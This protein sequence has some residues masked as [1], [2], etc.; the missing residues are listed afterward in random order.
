MKTIASSNPI[1][2]RYIDVHGRR[3]HFLEHGDEAAPS[4][5]LLHGCGSLAQE[6]LAP[7]RETDL[8]IVAPDRPGYGFSE[9][10]AGGRGPL[11]QSYWLEEL[12]EALQ[13]HDVVLAGHSI[14]CAPLLILAERR[15]DLVS[16]LCLIAPFC[17]P[18]PEQT[19]LLLRIAVA[20]AVGPLF[21]RHIV[22]RFAGYFG[23]R[24]MRAAHHP[25][26]IPQHLLEFPYQHAANYRAIC[27]MADELLG[28]N[29]D[30]ERAS[31]LEIGCPVQVLYGDADGAVDPHWHLEW[32]APRVPQADI[33]WLEGGGHNPHHAAPD[34]VCGMV[35]AMAYS[36]GKKNHTRLYADG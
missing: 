5:V 7:L 36:A 31:E 9:S 4:V 19:M 13:L 27:T 2:G 28:F 20:P 24:V 21:T 26:P 23:Q 8:H 22:Q 35:R 29:G 10:L 34:I 14:G 1:C 17:R 15:P 30:M 25:N 3:V 6:V 11:A 33:T 12:I 16:G 32:L 18:T